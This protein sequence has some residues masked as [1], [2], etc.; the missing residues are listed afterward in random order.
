VVGLTWSYPH[1]LFLT[2]LLSSFNSYSTSILRFQFYKI[3]LKSVILAGISR[4]K[5][6]KYI[7]LLELWNVM[8]NLVDI[9]SIP[10]SSNTSYTSIPNTDHR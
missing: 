7:V 10:V 6:E 2:Q 3:D 1:L 4:F 9:I 5:L 8:I